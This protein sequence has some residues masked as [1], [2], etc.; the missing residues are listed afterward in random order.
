MIT[1]YGHNSISG[2]IVSFNI[3]NYH[4]Y[5]IAKLLD[6]FKNANRS[7]H[8]CTQPLMKSL[9]TNFTNR[10]SFYAY[11]DFE[12]IEYFMDSLEKTINVLK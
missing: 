12:D 8:H 2:P 6:T 3:D 7:G 9:K 1:I 4:S 10:V 5:D 11:N